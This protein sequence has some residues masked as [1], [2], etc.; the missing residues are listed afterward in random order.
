MTTRSNNPKGRPLNTLGANTHKVI[1]LINE[2][3]HTLP[4]IAEIAGVTQHRISHIKRD[5]KHLITGRILKTSNKRNKR[6]RVIELPKDAIPAI[7][8]RRNGTYLPLDGYFVTPDARVFRKYPDHYAELS[9]SSNSAEYIQI[10]TKHNTVLLH[11]LVACTFIPCD[12]ITLV[13][14]HIDL[15]KHNCAVDNL[16]WVTH[17]ENMANRRN[18]KQ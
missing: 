14:D 10:G 6:Q 17:K 12:D 4:A 13:V 8:R 15:D 11:R 2:S 1:S 3:K 5:Q 16:R 7:Y 9:Q 18:S